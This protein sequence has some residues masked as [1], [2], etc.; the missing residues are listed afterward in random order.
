MSMTYDDILNSGLLELYVLG[1]V[2]ASEKE[3]VEKALKEFPQLK[4][5][6]MEIEKAFEVYAQSRGVVPDPNL[7][8]R[9]SRRLGGS[10]GNSLLLISGLAIVMAGLA[11]WFFSQNRQSSLEI[12]ELRQEVIDC[13]EREETSQLRMALLDGI[14]DPDN[15]ILD[16]AA[17]PKYPETQIYFYLNDTDQRNYLQFKNLP[18]ITADQSYQLWSLKADVDPIPLD[19]FEG[20]EA[21]IPVQ[22]VDGTAT[23]AITIE[24]RGGRQ[25][26]TLE[27]LVGTFSVEG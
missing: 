7:A 12:Q 23:Y 25:S 4:K 15:R 9:I 1:D 18:E 21:V 27:N 11:Y 14:S 10:N 26:P 8:D 24:P 19:V 2:T 3:A 13:E 17:T 20:G 6:L 16:I 5:E 22:Y